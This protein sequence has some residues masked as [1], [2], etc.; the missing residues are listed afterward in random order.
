M[1]TE[2]R[3]EGGASAH[4]L[5]AF[6]FPG[7]RVLLE[8]IVIG[9]LTVIFSAQLWAEGDSKNEC[10]TVTVWLPKDNYDPNGKVIMEVTPPLAG[11]AGK[12]SV[13]EYRY[14]DPPPRKTPPRKQA[15]ADHA[16]KRKAV[17]SQTKAD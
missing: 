5:R 15:P 3:C 10:T 11:K 1:L 7:W 9:I 13:W 6:H 4:P 12:C 8:W 17:E 2:R 16:N 14:G